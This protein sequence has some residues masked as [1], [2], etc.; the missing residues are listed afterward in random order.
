MLP[1][2]GTWANQQREPQWMKAANQKGERY[3][4]PLIFFPACIV[5]NS[6]SCLGMHAILFASPYKCAPFMSSTRCWSNAAG[7]AEACLHRALMVGR[8]SVVLRG[9]CVNDLSF[10][11]P[12][13]VSMC[14]FP[15][16]HAE[17]IHM[18]RPHILRIRKPE[19]MRGNSSCYMSWILP[20][21][22]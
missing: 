17:P 7:W 16:M 11:I 12:K 3:V 19:C 22:E 14:Q 8:M 10:C 2:W 20:T 13:L 6:C 5:H 4:P 18:L 15:H 1:G 9:S 21:N